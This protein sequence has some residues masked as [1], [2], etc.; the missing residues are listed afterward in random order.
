[1][2]GARRRRRAGAVLVAAGAL[3]GGGCGV[4][5]SEVVEAGSAATVEA[6]GGRESMVFFVSP[7]GRL[8]PVFLTPE[9]YISIGPD[10]TRSSSGETEAVRTDKLVA[11]LLRGPRGEDRAVGLTTAL[12]PLRTRETVQIQT[13][14]DDGPVRA[15]LPIAVRGLN[16][17]ALRQLICTVAYSQAR[18]GRVTVRLRGR[19]GVAHSDTCGL[20]PGG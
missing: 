20:D 5:E 19:D 17:T 3:L 12:P 13:P 18:D 8:S 16:G 14:P 1:M 15:D 2:R 6:F 4:H 11:M 10:G 7:D 9:S